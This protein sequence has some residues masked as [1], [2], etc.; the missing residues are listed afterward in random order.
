MPDDNLTRYSRQMLLPQIGRTGQQTLA[1]S[2]V[3]IVGSG[4]LGCSI[5]QVLVRGGVGQVTLYDDEKIELS[6][7]HRQILFD[8][9]DIG[10]FKSAVAAEK[11][12]GINSQVRVQSVVERV[13]RENVASL[14]EK[15]DLVI[16]A[17]DNI[18]SRYLLNEA[19]V[20]IGS[21]WMYGG[22]VGMTGTILLI[23]KGGA[24]LEC[25]FGPMQEC[26]STPVGA[27]PVG[28]ATPVIVGAIQA[29][30]TIKYLLKK[31]APIPDNS[32]PSEYI[33]IDL[34]QLRV[35]SNT[36]TKQNTS[37]R[38]CSQGNSTR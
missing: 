19:A 32:Y 1:A 25:V 9:N 36:I 30:E 10:G 4:G 14:F 31:N 22:C 6:N 24:C 35:R 38:L 29:N 17:T 26:D 28:P 13:R 8:E 15:Y 2:K 11:L 18:P 33:S 23:R 5:A 20:T 12:S 34:W 21:N 37:C 16:D 27:F 7:L 3:V